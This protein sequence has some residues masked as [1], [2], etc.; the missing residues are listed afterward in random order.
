MTPSSSYRV[1]Y[2]ETLGKT[3]E[4]ILEGDAAR[5]GDR[6]ASTRER[7]SPDVRV[8]RH[9]SAVIEAVA[10]VTPTS[11]RT[12][13]ARFGHFRDWVRSKYGLRELILPEKYRVEED[14]DVVVT[15]SSC[16]ALLY[17]ADDAARLDLTDIARDSRRANLYLELLTIR[18]SGLLGTLNGPSSIWR[19]QQGRAIIV[20]DGS[21]CSRANPL[22]RYESS[23]LV[24]ARSSISCHSQRRATSPSSERTTATRSC[25]STIRSARTARR[26]QSAASLLDW[27]AHLAARARPHRRRARHS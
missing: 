22:E 23:E 24:C 7:A 18:A 3:V 9:G 2:G 13:A 26:G 11:Q 27:A 12:F 19:V 8:R 1:L 5:R 10:Q 21:K 6:A 25:R 16:L 14:H 15:Y 20:D 4:R 17:F